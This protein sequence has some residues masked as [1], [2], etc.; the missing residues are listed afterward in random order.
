MKLTS[1]GILI[2]IAASNGSNTITKAHT[3][4]TFPLSLDM[5]FQNSFPFPSDSKTS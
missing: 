3:S 1:K 5:I 4:D 2:S